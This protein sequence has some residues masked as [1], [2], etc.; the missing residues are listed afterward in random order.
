MTQPIQF[1]YLYYN[2]DKHQESP[3][4]MNEVMPHLFADCD[5]H[6]AVIVDLHER[7]RYF[8]GRWDELATMT[9]SGPT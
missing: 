1:R 5:A 3:V 4:L 7:R 2:I 8:A 6:E 9:L